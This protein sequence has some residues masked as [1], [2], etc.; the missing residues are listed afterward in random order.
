MSRIYS[1]DVPADVYL[2]TE[3]PDSSGF[4]VK[5]LVKIYTVD[6]DLQPTGGKA[7]FTA[8][9]LEKVT[10]GAMRAFC[11]SDVLSMG[12][13]VS[14]NGQTYLVKGLR[15]WYSHQEAILEPFT[16]DLP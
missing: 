7:D 8:Y 6:L 11:D 10:S 3:T 15:D 16:V 4:M 14:V 13:A 9:G 1:N 12:N 5:T 2:I